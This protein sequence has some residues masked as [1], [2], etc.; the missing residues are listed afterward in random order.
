MANNSDTEEI[1]VRNISPSRII[2][3][4][5]EC[6]ADDW[7]SEEFEWANSETLEEQVTSWCTWFTDN[8]P[9]DAEPDKIAYAKQWDV[10]FRIF[11]IAFPAPGAY[12]LRL[13]NACYG[14]DK[15]ICGVSS[16]TSQ[17]VEKWRDMNHFEYL[18]SE[19]LISRWKIGLCQL[20]DDIDQDNSSRLA[21][22]IRV[23]DIEAAAAAL[24]DA[25]KN[26]FWDNVFTNFT[27]NSGWPSSS[28]L[29]RRIDARQRLISISVAT[30]KESVRAARERGYPNP[31]RSTVSDEAKPTASAGFRDQALLNEGKHMFINQ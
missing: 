24:D 15:A 29:E 16:I 1:S 23:Q 20:Q 12:L 14:I 18:R 22:L 13:V 11:F 10:D 21:N 30:L 9:P 17:E 26:D 6:F 28:K 4:I 8:H 19:D 27:E 25:L 7:D 5:V 2:S 3:E 31:K